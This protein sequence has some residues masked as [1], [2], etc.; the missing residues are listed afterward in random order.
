MQY[1]VHL[2][3]SLINQAVLALAAGAALPA[4]AGIVS[5]GDF[6]PNPGGGTVTGFL[7]VGRTT[8]GSVT[9]D[10]GGSLSMD[11][12]RQG[13]TLTGNG[14]FTASGAGTQV[15]VT[16][17]NTALTSNYEVNVG[18]L[19]TGSL[20]VLNGA[21]FV[22]GSASDSN[23]QANCRIFLSTG[24][25]SSGS[26][27]VSGAGSSFS[28]PGGVVV[29]NAAVFSQATDGFN[30][31]IPGA[32]A[33]GS[34][35]VLAGATLTSSFVNIG[36]PGG[37]L[38]RTGSET[39][40]GTV[41]VDGSNSIWNLV[42]NAAQTGAQALLRLA[43]GANT[44]ATLQ[45]RNGGVMVLDGAASRN[46]L[47]GMN[48][49]PGVGISGSNA[50]A[51]A[52]VDGAGSRLDFTGG[53]G[54]ANVGRGQGTVADMHVT[55]GGV[56]S[57]S[58]AG[59]SGLTFLQVGRNGGTGTLEV[60]GSGSLVRLNGIDTSN[61][62]GVGGAFM[63]VGRF[64]SGLAGHGTV[65]IHS[66][67]RLA[68]DTLG[69]V[70][71]N[72]NAQTGMY[73]GIGVGST[74]TINVS[75]A[76]SRLDIN[77]DS[78]MAP[79]IAVG[80][81]GATG[82]MLISG[83]GKVEVS[84]SHVSVPNPGTTT[85]LPGDVLLFDIG[86]RVGNADNASSVGS[87]TVTGA[88]SELALT[89]S[90]DNLLVIGR[91]NN[92][93]GTLNLL[94]G[95]QARAMSVL[96]GTDA[97]ASGTL[98]MNAGTLVVNGAPNGGPGVGFG[99]G[100]GVGRSGGVG[101]LNVG[102][103][104]VVTISSNAPQSS[105]SIGGTATAPGG[106]GT[107][108]VSGGSSISVSG[109]DAFVAVGR[110]ASATAAGIGTLS[111]TGSGSSVSATGSNAN[112][113]IGAGANTIG[114]VSVGAGASLSATSLIGVAHDGAANTGGVGALIVN[115]TVNAANL[116]V[117]SAGALGGS[118][119]IN[120]NVTNLGTINP[121]NSPGRLTI[122]G[123]FD[124][125][126]GHIVLEVQ[127]LGGGQFA[128]D[129][130]VFGDVSQ[131]TMG[132]GA[133]EFVF[134]GNTSPLDFLNTGL[135]DLA[136]F[137][138][139]TTSTGAVVGLGSGGRSLFSGSLFSARADA[140]TITNFVFNPAGGVRFNAVPVSAPQTLTLALLALAL[141]GAQGLTRRRA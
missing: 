63:Q 40:T 74:A 138:K 53:N 46:D 87:V 119:V 135:F 110:N 88:G 125:S 51:T 99:N 129:E 85:Y 72:A 75:G 127:S 60:A 79:Y 56:M 27:L 30:F 1:A 113:R 19:G 108:N 21:S 132:A 90:S 139:E 17:V 70:L 67:G 115:G 58:G 36:N 136:S 14:A 10:G 25:G 59:G 41:V 77:A 69:F 122:N 6:N 76:N 124:S 47:S 91:G 15:S 32:S 71:A 28:T 137:F 104:S 43:Q 61:T 62:S 33:Q 81:D 11:R 120:A 114:T 92:A 109:P 12:L 73:V 96:I 52:V 50:R 42:R 22:A 111:I 97:N 117:G 66:G 5:L 45:V 4:G 101:T 116:I 123:A 86:R 118:G 26:L 29:G 20:S 2:S 133:V 16:M 34:A 102:N 78:G 18:H 24:A 68:I 98:N 103:G 23:C 94:N 80:R 49:G 65:D 38:A 95:G 3:R 141:M 128:Y 13:T 9:V 130:I 140:Y 105:L 93:T 106:T 89:G 7:D 54:F 37:G 83:G 100:V 64:E 134:L 112:V 82:N 121:G 35:S 131:V 84:S 39:S 126:A 57:G 55:N 48:M 107:V 8:T 31:G 44:N